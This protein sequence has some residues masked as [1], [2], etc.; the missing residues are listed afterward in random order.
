M[1]R[2]L[3]S[4]KDAYITNRIIDNSFRAVDTNV[5]HAAT[6]DLF[7][8]FD[9]STLTG[10]TQPIELS[11]LLVKFDLNYLRA[12]TGSI[13]DLN[14]DSFKATLILKDVVGGQPSP[15]N[16]TV[17]V[18]PISKSWDEG[19]GKDVGRYSDLDA[20]NWLTASVSTGL[21]IWN[22]E[23][24]N[25]EGALGS[26]NIDIIGS[27][28]LNDGNGFRILHKT[29]LFET[30]YENLEVDV[31][32]IV[33]ATLVGL[34]PDQGY[35][36]SFSGSHELNSSSLFVKR[37]GARQANN[38]KLHPKLVIKFDDSIH[39]NHQNF[40]FN[41][42]GSL[43]MFNSVRGQ[44]RNFVSGAA[45]TQLSGSNALTLKLISGSISPQVSQ[46]FST[47]VNV[48]QYARGQ[49]Y[50]SGTYIA[51]FAISSF[52]S[53]LRREIDLVGSAT[54]HTIWGSNDGTVPYNT[55]TLVIK[56]SDSD[57]FV[58]H[59]RN[60]IVTMPNI[61][62]TYKLDAVPRISVN[63]F[64]TSID[65]SARFT[66]LPIEKQ[67]MILDV[68]YWRLI[69]VYAG[70][71]VIP[72]DIT[73]DSTRVSNDSKGMYFDFY[74][75]DLSIGRVY[76][77]EFLIIDNGEEIIIDRNLPTFRIEP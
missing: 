10:S 51:T 4:N 54:F 70:E 8:L 64:D 41:T 58:T 47:T 28:N 46:S 67:S 73:D 27:G 31:T 26:T 38:P 45:A 71:I 12:V 56:T 11:R 34:L 72:F 3:K 43:F 7:K 21:D 15:A 25:A 6:L 30:G 1:Y 63:V 9:E 37:F 52:T 60:L 40:V 65:M 48:N 68:M 76:G 16:F 59:E 23:G 44:L 42:T 33:S 50:V 53:S 62:Q 35:R 13:V 5:G 22:L 66:K 61:R 55:G 75:I 69:D 49:N 74:P 36:I 19:I 20:T 29:Q 57:N 77:F 32:D 17:I 18:H 2:L 14:S 24:A 39:D